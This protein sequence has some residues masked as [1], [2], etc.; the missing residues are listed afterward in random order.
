MRLSHVAIAERTLIKRRQ[1]DLAYVR[2]TTSA[3]HMITTP[4]LVL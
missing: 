2:L 4:H 3:G 1:K